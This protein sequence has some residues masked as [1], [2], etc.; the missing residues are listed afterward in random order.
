[1]SII[2]IVNLVLF[3]L[4]VI[5]FG[6]KRGIGFLIGTWLLSFIAG[7]IVGAIALLLTHSK[8]I[9]QIAICIVQAIVTFARIKGAVD[10]I[11]K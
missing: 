8:T 7:L 9:A 11:R 6:F 2:G 3:I 10:D 5:K 1:M 4:L